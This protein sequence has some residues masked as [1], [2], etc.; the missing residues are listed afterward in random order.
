[1]LRNRAD[2]ARAQNAERRMRVAENDLGVIDLPYLLLTLLLTA[3]GLIMLFSASFA[4]AYYLTGNSASYFTSQLLFAVLGV[5]VMFAVS[6][7]P[8]QWY[9]NCSRLI[10]LVTVGLLAAVLLVGTNVN[11]A[12]RWIN[13]GFTQF[14][15]SEVAKFS[16]IVSL[17]ALMTK[18]KGEIK[19]LRVFCLCAGAMLL[20]AVLLVL[21]PHFSAT[22]IIALLCFVMMAVGGVNR[23]YLGIVVAVGGA[24]L[25]FL[26]LS[27]GYTSERIT[28]W[29]DPE[30][31]P[32]DSGLQILQSEYAIGSGG[33]LG[34]GFG[35]GRQKYLYLPEEHNDYI[36][37]IICEEL[38]FVGAVTILLLFALLILRGYQIA[39]YARDRFS[40][41]LAVGLTT[42]LA[43]QVILNVAVVTN[44]LPATGISL[45][46]FSSGGT[47]L[48]MQLAECGIM[49][50]ISRS[51]SSK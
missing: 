27:G 31:D 48:I 23:K 49:L 10:Y 46:F 44:L 47:A 14:Q 50:G 33:L 29:L 5:A 13:L 17:S 7:V 43:V 24:A 16:L 30:S 37:A 25:L 36:F 11:G 45:P 20:I 41:L 19:S 42:L 34:L 12:T 18:R 3:V 35:R 15:P 1:M 38:G 26:L 6:R 9:R 8:Y 2:T 28:A 51:I 40:M 4:R 32:L 21:E 22:I 39:M